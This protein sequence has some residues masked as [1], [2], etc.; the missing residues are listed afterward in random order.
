M[1]VLVAGKGARVASKIKVAQKWQLPHSS[2]RIFQ[3]EQS[4]AEQTQSAECREA[5]RDAFEAEEEEADVLEETP[6]G[7][8]AAP[9][10]L[11]SAANS[12]GPISLKLR[13]SSVRARS[14]RKDASERTLL[15]DSD[16]SWS[17]ARSRF[18]QAGSNLVNGGSF[19]RSTRSRTA[20]RSSSP[21]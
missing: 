9:P 7:L 8:L 2:D 14:G 4:V 6:A 21:E 17:E 10:G 3:V 5:A 16:S 20:S 19:S 13:L 15:R 18:A 12:V 11:D 1:L